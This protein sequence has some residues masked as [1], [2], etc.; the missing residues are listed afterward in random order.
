MFDSAIFLY[1][2]TELAYTLPRPLH[3]CQYCRHMH[4][5]IAVLLNF[6][7][8]AI[9]SQALSMCLPRLDV[10]LQ[11]GSYAI[12]PNFLQGPSRYAFRTLLPVISALVSSNAQH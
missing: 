1:L 9:F 10:A 3:G 5:E 8:E 6:T 4:A 7:F 11:I 2:P 12:P